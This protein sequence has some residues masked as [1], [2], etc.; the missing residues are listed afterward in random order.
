MNLPKKL[1]EI[2]RTIYLWLLPCLILALLINRFFQS[3]DPLD[4]LASITNTLLLIWFTISWIMMLM[5]KAQRFIEFSNLA[6]ISILH[7]WTVYAAINHL[8]LYENDPLGGFTQY[9]PLFL[10]F[11]FF[12]LENKKGF[13][14]SLAVWLITVVIALIHYPQLSMIALDSISQFYISNIAYIIVF[15]FAQYIFR[16]SADMGL[17]KEMAYLDSLTEIA[18]RYQ[19]NQWLNEKIQLVEKEGRTYSVIFFDIDHFKI[20]ND[21]LGHGAGDQVLKDFV[22]LIKYNLRSGDCFG[23]WGG[24]EFI[25]I[26]ENPIHFTGEIA[27]A[28]RRCIQKHPFPGADGLTAS[29][30]VAEIQQG[31]SSDAILNRV[32]SALYF[33]KKNGRNQVN[34][35]VQKGIRAEE[36]DRDSTWAG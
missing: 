36:L 21:R 34:T 4:L 26:M 25:I 10:V 12:T 14:Y 2:K 15:Y 11:I 29:F 6:L 9:T 28:L 8:T 19:I 23:R 22:Y 30:G 7:I 27:E 1:D 17:M 3:V 5:R 32:D 13:L 16:I 24:E 20:I 35:N 31:D 33:S 18:N